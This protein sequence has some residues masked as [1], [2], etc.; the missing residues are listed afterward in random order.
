MWT[1]STLLSTKLLHSQ[2]LS[3]LLV[4]T[5]A[6]LLRLAPELA[7][8]PYPIGYDVVNYYIPVVTDLD[9]HWSSVSDDFPIYVLILSFVSGATGLS[10]H[11]TVSGAGVAIF[12]IFAGAVFY[13]ARTL[14]GR[15]NLESI[16]ITLFVIVQVAVLRTAW[17]L[18]RDI[19]AI[20]LMLVVFSLISAKRYHQWHWLA[21][22]S[23]L[24]CITV[25]LDRMIGLLFVVT[26]TT[27]LVTRRDRKIVLLSLAIL[28]WGV[29]LFL[30]APWLA[31]ET[32][33]LQ[34]AT[35]NAGKVPARASG[36]SSIDYLVLFGI[37]DA[38][39]T[40]PAIFGLRKSQS[41][42]LGVPMVISGVASFSW[43][44]LPNP[45]S[46]VPER[47]AILFGIFASIIAGYF[48]VDAI[49]SRRV[50]HTYFAGSILAVF[51]IVGVAYAIL[52]YESPFPLFA[53]VRGHTEQF[54]PVTM[55]FNAL[56]VHDTDALLQSI[57]NINRDTEG[58]AVIV[59]A[60]HWRGYMEL[61]LEAG[62]TYK[63]SENPG[64]LAAAHARLGS[65]VYLIAPAD[66]GK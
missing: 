52:P 21:I 1:P 65:N 57:G 23:S 22:I 2:N 24:C 33:H 36:A 7:A 31:G 4:V 50:R 37:L 32:T 55:Q 19:L 48:I 3:V 46:F 47:W 30:L 53:L 8:F 51:A 17:D 64:E 27:A 62:R 15:S 11:A 14:L 9:A 5:V 28:S 54:M 39:I 60:K 20:S 42:F 34:S 59:G 45:A 6:L 35:G 43:L 49:T 12:G 26:L 61:Y 58:D 29:L 38:A 66:G 44:V 16:F 10:G 41:V 40:V 13:A 56:D 63:Y 25:A 18:H